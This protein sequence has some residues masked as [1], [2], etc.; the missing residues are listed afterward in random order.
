M[1][2]SKTSKILPTSKELHLLCFSFPGLAKGKQKCIAPISMDRVP[3]IGHKTTPYEFEIPQCTFASPTTVPR[4]LVHA[5][6]P[7]S[8]SLT[9]RSTIHSYMPPTASKV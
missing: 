9:N 5:L 3:L 6:H 8:F 7:H 1:N 4:E 2:Y